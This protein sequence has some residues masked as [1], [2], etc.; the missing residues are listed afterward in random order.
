PW[1]GTLSTSGARGNR[2]I[3]RPARIPLSPPQPH[4]LARGDRM[5]P[6]TASQIQSADALLAARERWVARGVSAPAIVATRAEGSYIEAAD[7]TRYLDFA[8]G[9]GC[10]NL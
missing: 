1:P 4:P 8:G 7:G 6:M 5:L 2:A 3:S 9:I 10:Q